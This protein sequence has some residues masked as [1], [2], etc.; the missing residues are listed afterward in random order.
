LSDKTTVDNLEVE[1]F[2]RRQRVI[3]IAGE[4]DYEVLVTAEWLYE[5]NIEVKCVRVTLRKDADDSSE[6]LNFSVVFPPKEIDDEAKSRRVTKDSSEPAA[7]S[8]DETIASIT[9]PS[10]RTFFERHI[11]DGQDRDLLIPNRSDV[12][13]EMQNSEKNYWD[14]AQTSTMSIVEIDCASA[15]IHR[16]ISPRSMRRSRASLRT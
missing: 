11:Q 6:F 4:F 16:R 15:Y 12:F 8:W 1:G 5:Q 7:G 9:S 13:G 2:N 10:V 14:L 3:L